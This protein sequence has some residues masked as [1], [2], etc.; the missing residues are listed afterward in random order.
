MNGWLAGWLAGGGIRGEERE[1]VSRGVFCLHS[2]WIGRNCLYWTK[3]DF[4]ADLKYQPKMNCV[5]CSLLL[6]IFNRRET[7]RITV[8]E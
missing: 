1:G 5:H 4:A 6:L 3:D 8:A 7:T 2:K